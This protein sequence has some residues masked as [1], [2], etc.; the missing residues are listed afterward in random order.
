M[1]PV[2][3]GCEDPLRQ[4]LGSMNS[5]PG[6]ADPQ[7]PLVPFG[8]FDRLHFAR[9]LILTDPTATDIAVYGVTV[10]DLPPTLV[11]FGDCDGSADAFVRELAD[12]AAPGLQQIVACC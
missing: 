5:R 10:P 7:N 1:A 12:R 3:P 4:L 9:L 6:I 8:Q 2:L 11:F